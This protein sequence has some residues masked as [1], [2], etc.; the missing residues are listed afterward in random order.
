MAASFMASAPVLVQDEIL[1]YFSVEEAVSLMQANPETRSC[2]VENRPFWRKQAQRLVDIDSRAFHV[3]ADISLLND[4]NLVREV[5]QAEENYKDALDKIENNESEDDVLQ[6]QQAV[7]SLAFDPQTNQMAVLLANGDVEIY[8]TARF[9]DPPLRTIVNMI[10]YTEILI[11]GNALFLRPPLDSNRFHTDTHDWNMD[12][13]TTSLTPAFIH[14]DRF[15]LRQSETYLLATN[16]RTNTILAYPLTISGFDPD[17]LRLHFGQSDKIIDCAIHGSRVMVIVKSIGQ[18]VFLEFNL[19]RDGALVRN[20]LVAD[21]AVFH[22]PTIVHPF[23]LVTQRIVGADANRGFAFGA[24]RP[25]QGHFHDIQ[26]ESLIIR[27]VRI[28]CKF[29][30]ITHIKGFLEITISCN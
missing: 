23:V 6:L 27:D 11:H 30:I 14:M 3:L 7:E 29:C 12:I 17:C 20:F 25:I 28:G 1:S 26:D 4:E 10:R 18:H 22:A 15:Q 9:G 19:D 24:R 13:P 16:S 8:S 2:I 21:P 5:C